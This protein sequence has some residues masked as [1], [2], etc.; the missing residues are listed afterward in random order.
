[1]FVYI[2]IIFIYR[3]F[4]KQLEKAYGAPNA[5]LSKIESAAKIEELVGKEGTLCKTSLEN[6]LLK[7]VIITPVMQRN[8]AANKLSSELVFIDSSGS[9]DR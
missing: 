9:C 4:L 2:Y 5:A 7:V 8:H 1:M 6:D 3:H